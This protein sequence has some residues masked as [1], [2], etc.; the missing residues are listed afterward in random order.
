M[1]GISEVKCIQGRLYAKKCQC[2]FDLA[3]V[4]MSG[5]APKD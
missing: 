1:D 5:D 2:Y 4:R 3:L